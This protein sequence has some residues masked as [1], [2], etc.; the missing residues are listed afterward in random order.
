M[1]EM[2]GVY[3]VVPLNLR[4]SSCFHAELFPAFT[5]DINSLSK[6]KIEWKIEEKRETETEIATDSLL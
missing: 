6:R 3:D 1:C 4:P 2:F 5:F